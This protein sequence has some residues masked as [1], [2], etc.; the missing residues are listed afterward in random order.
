MSELNH[1]HTLLSSL[2]I[3][4][5]D[6]TDEAQFQGMLKWLRH[7]FS[8]AVQRDVKNVT[9]P[10]NTTLTFFLQY[11]SHILD[12]YEITQRRNQ[13]RWEIDTIMTPALSEN[14]YLNHPEMISMPTSGDVEEHCDLF[15]TILTKAI[16][17]LTLLRVK[18]DEASLFIQK[19][20]ESIEQ[21]ELQ[22]KKYQ[23]LLAVQ[24]REQ[25][26]RRQVR[27]RRQQRYKMYQQQQLLGKGEDVGGNGEDNDGDDGDDG[28]DGKG[29]LTNHVAGKGGN[30]GK[31]KKNK[32][33]KPCSIM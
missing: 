26:S 13:I 28:D 27:L 1:S 31:K 8:A 21:Q 4:A 32:V 11:N 5:Y 15:T 19:R 14:I 6:V 12:N 29:G 7:T 9:S 18:Q 16:I 30:T 22:Y 24:Q 23:E 17:N 25:E 3:V 20:P 33:D 10:L 2:R